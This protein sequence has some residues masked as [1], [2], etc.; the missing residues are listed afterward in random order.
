MSLLSM[1]IGSIPMDY[2]VPHESSDAGFYFR[3]FISAMLAFLMALVSYKAS[4]Q[5][6]YAIVIVNLGLLLSFITLSAPFY[7]YMVL[8]LTISPVVVMLRRIYG[9]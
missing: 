1:T 9:N 4:R 5:S 8:F 7:L 3:S 6:F 2:G